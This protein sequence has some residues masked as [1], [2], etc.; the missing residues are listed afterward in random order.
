MAET[1]SDR[2]PGDKS[3]RL[4]TE[5]ARQGRNVQGMI[6]VL[7]IGVAL[8]VVAYAVMLALQFKPAALVNESHV[9][10]S[11][12]TQS[13]GS[14]TSPPRSDITPAAPS[15]TASSPH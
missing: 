4:T 14:V 8:V 1:G 3:A 15:E 10:A 12:A 7:I 5:K 2:N 11:Q 9:A 6:Y 13:D